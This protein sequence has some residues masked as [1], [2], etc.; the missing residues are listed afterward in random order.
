[1]CP[2]YLDDVLKL[3]SLLMQG[4]LEPREAR[5]ERLVKLHGHGDVHGGGVGVVRALGRWGRCR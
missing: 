3:D 1:M 2:P 5:Q 4:L